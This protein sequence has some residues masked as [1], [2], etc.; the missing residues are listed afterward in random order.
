MATFT[1]L[2]DDKAETI[3]LA[4]KS[5]HLTGATSASIVVSPA[6]ASLLVVEHSQSATATAGQPFATQPV[7][8]EEDPFGNV[9]QNDS[10]TIVTV[11]L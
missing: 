3:T 9:E 7:I 4:F 2:S 11:A 1:N 5:G 6:A 10:S 8:E